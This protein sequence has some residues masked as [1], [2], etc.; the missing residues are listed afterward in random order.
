MYKFTISYQAF[1]FNGNF[2]KNGK[3][4]VNA[5]T[6]ESA[7]QYLDTHLRGKFKNY[8]YFTSVHHDVEKINTNDVNTSTVDYLFNLFKMHR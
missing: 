5:F 4:E 3:T 6:I 1:D 8:G 2:I 7:K